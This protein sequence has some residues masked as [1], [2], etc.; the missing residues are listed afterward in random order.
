MMLVKRRGFNPQCGFF[1][2][3]EV[4]WPLAFEHHHH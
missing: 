2:L 3:W 1:M 4:L